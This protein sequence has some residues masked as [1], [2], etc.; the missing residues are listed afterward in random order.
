[1][2]LLSLF[3]DDFTR[4]AAAWLISSRQL[5]GFLVLCHNLIVDKTV[6][7]T[8]LREHAAELKAAGIVHLRLHGSMARG[9]QTPASDV[10]LIADMD[11]NRRFSLLDMVRLERRLGEVVGV[12]VDL[13]PSHMLKDAVRERAKR[14]ALIAF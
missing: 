13:S 2:F 11:V 9:Q 1:M 12:P 5:R 14:E 7:I 6:I 4:R 10:D 3:H 8:T